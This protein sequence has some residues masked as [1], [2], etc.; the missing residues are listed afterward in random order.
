MTAPTIV[1]PALAALRPAAIRGY[2][3]TLDATGRA[4]ARAALRRYPCPTCSQPLTG[5]LAGCYR[6][7]CVAAEIADDARYEED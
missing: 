1:A 7:E 6:P 3:A 5:A 2:V 4:T